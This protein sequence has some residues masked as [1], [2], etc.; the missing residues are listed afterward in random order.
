MGTRSH[1]AKKGYWRSFSLLPDTCELGEEIRSFEN[2]CRVH[3]LR[4]PH[5]EW[6]YQPPGVSDAVMIT[7]VDELLMQ[8]LRE[9]WLTI[10]YR[11]M[12]K[13]GSR[14]CMIM[15]CSLLYSY[16]KFVCRRHWSFS[17]WHR[18]FDPDWKSTPSHVEQDFT[19]PIQAA[20]DLDDFHY[21]EFVKNL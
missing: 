16:R 1:G 10:K 19:G 21:T 4:L 15:V 8:L 12:S 13:K 9:F 20:K 2:I 14:S 17:S 18:T 7:R 3:R 5:V 11:K 6:G